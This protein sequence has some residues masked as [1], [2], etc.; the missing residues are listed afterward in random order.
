MLFLGISLASSGS[1][2][3]LHPFEDLLMPFPAV[4]GVENPVLYSGVRNIVSVMS[5]IATAIDA[6]VLTF[7]FG[8]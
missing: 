8:K 5:E 4:I 6:V 3:F 7:S 2:E 1:N